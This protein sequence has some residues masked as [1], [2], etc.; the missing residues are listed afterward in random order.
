MFNES[1][2]VSLTNRAWTSGRVPGTGKR[3]S[4]IYLPAVLSRPRDHKASSCYFDAGLS[5]AEA[6]Q[7]CFGR[8]H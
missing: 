7:A 4:G 1:K 5:P 2:Y 8:N 3:R 6:A